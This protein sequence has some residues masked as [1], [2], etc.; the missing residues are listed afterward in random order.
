MRK[1]LQLSQIQHGLDHHL[2]RAHAPGP[3]P[4]GSFTGVRGDVADHAML[5][6]GADTMSKKTMNHSITQEIKSAKK[7]IAFLQIPF[8]RRVFRNEFHAAFYINFQTQWE[9]RVF[10]VMCEATR[11]FKTAVLQRR[12]SLSNHQ[13]S[14]TLITRRTGRVYVS[15]CSDFRRILV[16]FILNKP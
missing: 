4:P 13:M 12:Q 9:N 2:Q 15:S 3:A 7:L 14:N 5:K 8:A 1:R 10:H 11:G 16:T 6:E